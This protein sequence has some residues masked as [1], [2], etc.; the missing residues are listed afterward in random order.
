MVIIIGRMKIKRYIGA[1]YNL[2]ALKLKYI[3]VGVAGFWLIRI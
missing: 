2:I 1:H 3:I